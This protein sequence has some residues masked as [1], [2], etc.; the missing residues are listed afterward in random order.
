MNQRRQL[1]AAMAGLLA[2]PGLWAQA[3][4]TAE[5]RLA[6]L[7]PRRLKPGDTI[8]LVN[9]SGAIYEREPYALTTET[10]VALGFKVREGA[11]LRVR[12]TH[13][14]TGLIA[15]EKPPQALEVAGADRVFQRAK[16]RIERDTLLVSTPGVKEPVAVRY[17]WENSPEANLYNGA[18]LPAVPF[19]SDD[20]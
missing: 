11:N 4:P 1:L 6:V 10:L 5:Q 19:R 14:S 17:A 3:P 18:G 13:V 7:R 12:F 15:A 20:W 8:G 2:A 16:G 9:P